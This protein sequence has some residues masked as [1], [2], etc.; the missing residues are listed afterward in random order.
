[1]LKTM[2]SES[3]YYNEKTKE[4]DDISV[5]NGLES[6]TKDFKDGA[7]IECRDTLIAIINAI[8][9]WEQENAL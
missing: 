5:V 4:L 6:A 8:Y 7:I 1:M 3:Y 2:C 9:D